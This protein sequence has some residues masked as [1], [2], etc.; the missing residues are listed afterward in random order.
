MNACGVKSFR[1]RVI[2]FWRV[3][4]RQRRRKCHPYTIS[5]KS[6][7]FHS[8]F[9]DFYA[10][11]M[12]VEASTSPLVRPF[13]WVLSFV[14]RSKCLQG[15]IMEKCF[16][17]WIIIPSSVWYRLAE[18][19]VIRRKNVFVVGHSEC[20]KS[21]TQPEAEMIYAME[22]TSFIIN[23]PFAFIIKHKISL[24]SEKD[25]ENSNFIEFVQLYSKRVS[26]SK[27]TL[28][29]N[30]SWSPCISTIGYFSW[31]KSSDIAIAQ[32]LGKHFGDLRSQQ[33]RNEWRRI[34]PFF[35]FALQMQI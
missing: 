17:L 9:P 8:S 2:V 12:L 13:G 32:I 20:M 22:W 6:R 31:R 34:R 23:E 33:S 30:C 18:Q 19:K 7:C 29:G 4:Q 35:A 3:S 16:S 11:Y 28:W 27:S 24:F 5:H 26:Y 10:V 25:N 15:I 1:T 21:W 14:F